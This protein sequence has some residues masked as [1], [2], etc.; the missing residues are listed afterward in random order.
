MSTGFRTAKRCCKGA[1]LM[2]CGSCSRWGRR[3]VCW[4]MF[5]TSPGKAEDAKRLG[6][7]EVIIPK[8]A[9][10]M[11][12]H[13]GTFDMILDCVS[14]D[15]DVNPCLHLVRTGGNQTRVDAPEKPLPVPRSR[16]PSGTRRSAGR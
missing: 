1:Y 13:A 7:D 16:S 9:D 14:A 3:Q 4:R 15:H 12:R 8:N 10:E 5:T 2:L 11:K 6:A